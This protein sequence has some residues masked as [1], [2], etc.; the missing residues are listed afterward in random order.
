MSLFEVIRSSA[1]TS[2][3][4]LRKSFGKKLSGV[5]GRGNIL[6]LCFSIHEFFSMKMSGPWFSASRFKRYSSYVSL[7]ISRY[8]IATWVFASLYEVMMFDQIFRVSP[9]PQNSR[10]TAGGGGHAKYLVKHHN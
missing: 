3:K 4:S 10:V 9:T 2:T 8:S 6:S 5:S 7:S 1:V